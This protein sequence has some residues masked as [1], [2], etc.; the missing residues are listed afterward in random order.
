MKNKEV[1]EITD[2]SGG[3]DKKT[4]FY[5]HIFRNKSNRKRFFIAILSNIILFTLFKFFCPN[6][7]FNADSNGY[8]VAA[9][10]KYEVYYRPYGYPQFLQ[11]VHSISKK[12]DFL[13]WTQFLLLFFAGQFIFFSIDYLFSISRPLIR[14]LFWLLVTFNPVLFILSNFV[15]SDAVFTALSAIYITLLLWVICRPNILVVLLQAILLYLAFKVR[16]VALYYPVLTLIAI[17]LSKKLNIGVKSLGI[18]GSFLLIFSTYKHTKS[19]VNEVTNVDAFS[20]FSGWQ[21]ANN[22]LGVYP[23]ISI[24][25]NEFSNQEEKLLH[26]ITSIYLD[27]IAPIYLKKVK[28]GNLTSA[29]L[30]DTRSPLKVFTYVKKYKNRQTYF[31]TWYQVSTTF[32]DFGVTVIK[33]HPGAFVRYFIWPNTKLF[34]LPE[35]EDMASYDTSFVALPK[36]TVE[37]FDIKTKQNLNGVPQFQYVTSIYSK[38]LVLIIS[39]L[40]LFLPILYFVVRWK[41][42]P[43]V[44]LL[45]DRVVLF[46]FLFTVFNMAFSIF[47]AMIVL[48]YQC[49]L[50]II[51][52]GFP[53]MLLDRLF[54]SK[55]IIQS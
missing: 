32:N 51:G 21:M 42:R 45:E 53:L 16:F 50:L 4:T 54:P 48:R 8:I 41:Q 23:F 19:K 10:N 7:F 35:S 37:W 15:L 43:K 27:S 47:A 26:N 6:A 36:E 49:L 34:F 1:L 28:S 20:G 25:S 40:N 24:D 3:K 12:L 9:L 46:W 29:F 38:I 39:L 31:A 11:I 5:S 55:K 33:N 2:P 13:I 22:V 44:F 18:I 17:L 52:I 14:K 30:W